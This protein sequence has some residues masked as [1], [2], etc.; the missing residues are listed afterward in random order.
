MQSGS[1]LWNRLRNELVA[2]L[3]PISYAERLGWDLFDWQRDFLLDTSLRR[4]LLCARQSGKSTIISVESCHTAKYHPKSLIPII[5]PSKDQ[6]KEV[7][8]KVDE[9]VLSDEAIRELRHNAVF[10]KELTNRSRIMALP[11]TERSVRGYSAPAEVVM[12]EAARILDATYWAVR[13]MMVG[14][15]TRLVLLS[16][17]FGTVGFFYRAWIRQDGPWSKYLV[18]PRYTLNADNKIV[19]GPPED[20][21][22]EMWAEQGVR[23]Y[24]SPRHTRE[25]LEDELAELGP[26]WFR[27]EYLC[28]FLEPEH[29][30]FSARD[31]KA[32]FDDDLEPWSPGGGALDDDLEPVEV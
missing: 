12:D 25:F 4:L 3:D 16:T 6:S 15:P 29:S 24:Y 31:I 23:A 2:S 32:A 9:L 10:E 20:E 17:A 8:K 1:Q 19:L 26:Y 18:V 14:T 7:I 28:E 11:G 21:F 27:Q 5:C 22:R 30:L 13:P